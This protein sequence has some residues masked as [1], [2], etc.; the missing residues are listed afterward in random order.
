MTGGMWIRDEK[1]GEKKAAT[2]GS[3]KPAPTKPKAKGKE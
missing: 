1:T 2:R 3:T